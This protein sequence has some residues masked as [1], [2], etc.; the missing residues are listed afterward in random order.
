MLD[1]V[2]RVHDEVVN[3]WRG[4]RGLL[5]LAGLVG[6][7]QDSRCLGGGDLNCEVVC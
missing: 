6:W 7:H 4:W 1:R 3:R 2:R 5:E